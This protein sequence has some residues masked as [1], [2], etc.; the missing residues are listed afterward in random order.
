MR[1]LRLFVFGM[2]MAAMAGGH[3]VFAADAAKI[4]VVDFQKVLTESE[5]GKSVEA[6]MQKRGK[7]MESGLRDLGTQ[8]E[9]LTEQLNKDAMVLTKEKR[10]EKQRE[11]E[12]K[13]YDF[14]NMQKKYQS[15]FRDL[16]AKYIDKLKKEI[17]ELAKEIGQKEGYL[18]VIEQ[19]AVLYYPESIDITA[20]LV[21]AY[22]KKYPGEKA[23]ST[24]SE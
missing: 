2:I 3:P 4:G 22:N 5:S 8:I 20:K 9:Q 10:D 18:L 19:S 14:Q 24:S 12:I 21:E 11:L 1:L 15:E 23:P 16:E 13:K 7:E 17:F 6:T